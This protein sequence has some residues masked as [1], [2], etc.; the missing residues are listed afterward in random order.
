MKI[1]TG[2][3]IHPGHDERRRAQFRTS[4]TTL[5]SPFDRSCI[6]PGSDDSSWAGFFHRHWSFSSSLGRVGLGF[7]RTQHIAWTERSCACGQKQ[8][9]G[10]LRCCCRCRCHCRRCCCGG[11]VGC[12][13]HA[14]VLVLHGFLSRSCIGQAWHGMAS[15]TQQAAVVV[16]ILILGANRIGAGIGASCPF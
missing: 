2:I 7:T 5:A 14:C 3:P 11:L 13:A 9:L 4:S 10:K 6:R 15:A 8:K 16:I 1:R 12:V